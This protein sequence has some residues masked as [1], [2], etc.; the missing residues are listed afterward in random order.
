MIEYMERKY[1]T[2]V[3]GFGP[4]L[5]LIPVAAVI[6]VGLW[7]WIVGASYIVRWFA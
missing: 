7:L 4:I 3:D 1:D 2:W 6:V 5:A